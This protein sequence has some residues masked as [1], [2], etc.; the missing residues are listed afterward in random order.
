MDEILP[1]LYL[2]SMEDAAKAPP[3]VI[4]ICVLEMC[5]PYHADRPGTIHIPI[6]RNEGGEG[7]ADLGQLDLAMT[8]IHGLVAIG[9]EVL[10][11]CGAGVE[12]SPLTMAWYLFN[13]GVLPTMDAA[14]EYVIKRRPSAQRRDAM[15]LPT[16]PPT[17]VT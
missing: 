16:E 11:H 12:R 4:R 1:G 13:T 9:E 5:S 15:W 6:L 10:V 7:R 14:Y 2:G 3:E 8:V 17:G